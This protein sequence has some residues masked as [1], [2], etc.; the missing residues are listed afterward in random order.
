MSTNLVGKA[1]GEVPITLDK[2]WRFL[3]APGSHVCHVAGLEELAMSMIRTLTLIT[4][5]TAGTAAFADPAAKAPAEK[6]ADKP[7]DKKADKPADKPAATDKAAAKKE[8]L[9]EAEAQKFVAF[10]D[11]LV[12]IVVATKDDCTKMAAGVNG[13]V[14]AN[15]P[16][17][18][19]MS[20]AKNQNKD[21]P[22]SVKDKIA[23]KSKDELAPAMMAKCSNDKSVQDAFMR[24]R[25]SK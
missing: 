23:K 2:L 9:S 22:P 25:P 3:C 6:K 11:K 14:D 15:Q 1:P 18:K 7:A 21:L 8:T 4:A 10:F 17:I 5:L 13:H 12:A 20:D 16:L 19:E 24:M